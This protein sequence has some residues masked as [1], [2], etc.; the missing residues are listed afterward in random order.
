ML[1]FVHIEKT[2]GTSI[3]W[4]LRSTFGI[5]HCDAQ[6]WYAR[7]TPTPFSPHDLRLLRRLYPR[8]ESIAG[9]RITPYAGLEEVYPHIRYFAFLRDP[10][11]RC[12]SYF[13]YVTQLHGETRA[14]EDWIQTEFPRNMETKRLTGSDD[15]NAAV[16]M[17]EEKDIF[18]GLV[19][20]FDESLLLL[21]SRVA[22]N[23]NISYERLNVA[24]DNTPA[25]HLLRSERTRQMLVE[26]NQ[27]DLELHAYVEQQ[28]YPAYRRE[29]GTG[30]DQD[31][32]NYQQNRGRFDRR[33]VIVN[34]VYRNLVYKPALKLYRWRLHY[35]GAGEQV[36]AS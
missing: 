10:L 21:K 30:L 31:V 8:L 22:N 5:R 25:Q 34:R 17:I 36:R 15:V 26:A 19:E 35:P 18:V 33:N 14:F 27:S 28:L 7:F 16:R 12:A 32:V 13:Q 29:Y 6:P 1:A 2:D 4:I 24:F 3:F 23:L 9:H 20:R 11:K